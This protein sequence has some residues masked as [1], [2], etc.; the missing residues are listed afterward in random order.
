MAV[1]AKVELPSGETRDLYIRLNNFEQLAN[2]GVPAIARF[3]GWIS[4]EACD[5]D[6]AFVWERLVEFEADAP[7]D[8][9][10]LAY[11]ALKAIPDFAKAKDV[12][13]E[14]RPKRQAKLAKAEASEK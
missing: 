2:H 4:Q 10:S 5:A 1:T 14:P 8:A 9:W 13:G 11:D 6:K 12:M 7:K 3:R